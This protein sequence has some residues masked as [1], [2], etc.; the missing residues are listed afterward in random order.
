MLGTHKRWL[1]L[2]AL[3][4]LFLS[5]GP[6]SAADSATDTPANGDAGV[7]PKPAAVQALAIHP[8][9]IAL[10]GGDDPQQLI[11]TATIAG[12]RLQD[13]SSDAKYEA[14]DPKV[15]RVSTAGRVVPLANG[16]TEITVSYGDKSVKVP[17]T[18]EL[19]D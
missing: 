16:S 17:V 8:G 12:G 6:L 3:A 11:L 10:K 19:I 4:A 1:V 7:L 9:Q 18:A 15:I 14:A 5:G 13:L 2:T